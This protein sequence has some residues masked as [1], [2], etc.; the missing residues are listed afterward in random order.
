MI[1]TQ[2]QLTE[3]QMRRLRQA[4]RAQ[5]VSMAELIRRLVDKGIEDELPDRRAAYARATARL[6]AFR[7]RDDAADVSERHDHYLEDAYR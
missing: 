6:G 3:I 4:A 5:G 2:I 7:D 1:R